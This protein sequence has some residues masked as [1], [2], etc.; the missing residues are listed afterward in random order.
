MSYHELKERFVKLLDTEFDSIYE[1]YERLSDL[2]EDM[3][4]ELLLSKRSL[5]LLKRNV[6]TEISSYYP[7]I[8]KD[9]TISC[10]RNNHLVGTQFLENP[11]FTKLYEL[12]LY[13]LSDED[14]CI[15]TVEQLNYIFRFLR[16]EWELKGCSYYINFD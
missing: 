16:G 10:F 7:R 6:P 4:A 5:Y 15:R 2:A 8:T 12:G 9:P 14:Y 3:L 13:A 11:D 1:R